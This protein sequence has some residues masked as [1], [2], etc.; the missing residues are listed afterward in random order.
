MYIPGL[1]Q[2]VHRWW[3]RWVKRGRTGPARQAIDGSF[4][5]TF[6]PRYR[7]TMFLLLAGFSALYVVG[8]R[9]GLFRMGS[10]REGVGAVVF[11]LIGFV[12][13]SVFVASLVEQLTVTPLH[14]RR[15]SWRGRQ[16][17]AW[18]DVNVVDIDSDNGDLKIG[19]SGGTVIEVS[20]YLD[21]LQAID[22]A[23]QQHLDVPPDHLE[24]VVPPRAIEIR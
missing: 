22:A 15:R 16:E 11:V 19:V 17:V 1:D 8:L 12:S 21:G 2:A 10:W 13:A 14:L 24:D 23:L 4:V 7:V 3:S 6:T 5:L 18:H 20:L 9:E